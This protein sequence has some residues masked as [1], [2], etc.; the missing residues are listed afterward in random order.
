M[1]TE[2]FQNSVHFF[3][4]EDA[5]CSETNEKSIFRFLVSELWLFVLLKIGLI[6]EEF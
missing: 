3:V 2:N 5:Q 1:V 6:F 4:P